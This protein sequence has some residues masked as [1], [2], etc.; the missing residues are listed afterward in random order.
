M[1]GDA[2][3]FM[4]DFDRWGSEAYVHGLTDEAM[5]DTG[6]MPL[7]FEMII[8]MDPRLTPFGI[9][10]GSGGKRFEGGIFARQKLRVTR[11]GEFLEGTIVEGCQ[12]GGDGGI[13]L[14]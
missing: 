1:R 5:G 10:I 11:A 3:A 4:E 9:L 2:L 12:Q 7:D 8:E 14:G 13:E 6:E